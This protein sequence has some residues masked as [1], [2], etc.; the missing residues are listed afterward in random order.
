MTGSAVDTAEDAAAA[1]RDGGSDDDLPPG[2]ANHSGRA[3]NIKKALEELKRRDV[4][5]TEADAADRSRIAG[6]LA[7]L[8]AGRARNGPPPAGVD[9]VVWHRARIT[10]VTKLIGELDGVRGRVGGRPAAGWRRD[11]RVRLATAQRALAKAEQVDA[12]DID[13]R[14]RAARKR[15]R[16]AAKAHARG[17]LGE[18]VNT[19]DPESRL[20]TEGSGGGSVQGYNA[21]IAVTDDHLILGIHVSQD[22]NDTGCYTPTLKAATTQANTLGKNIELVLADAGYFTDDNLAAT[23]PDRLIAPGRNREVHTAARDDPAHGPPPEDADPKDTM[24]HRL[25]EPANAK[26]YKRRSA[27]VEPVIAHLKDQTQLR[28]FARRGLQAATAEL[29]LAAA[30]INLTRLHHGRPAA[31]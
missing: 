15:D 19:T 17:A 26:L 9:P 4:D 7:D 10:G 28:R 13:L 21:Q 25:R 12:A 3:A 6:L 31:G 11:L 29:N 18:A 14:G 27:T 30:A 20:M 16:R 2:F 5:N 1:A 8:E 22:A 23:G 24:R